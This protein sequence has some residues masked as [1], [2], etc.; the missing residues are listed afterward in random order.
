MMGAGV[1]G[2]ITILTV[3][4]TARQPLTGSSPAVATKAE[5]Q[6]LIDKLR[7]RS[8]PTAAPAK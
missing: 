8:K 4:E 3:H 6:R 1:I 2:L 7:K 5:A